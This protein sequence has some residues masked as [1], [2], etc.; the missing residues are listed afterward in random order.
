MSWAIFRASVVAL[1]GCIGL[2]AA[3][4]PALAAKIEHTSLGEGI[5]LITIEGTIASGDEE[6]FRRL[7][8]QYDNAIVALASDGGALL[9]ALEIGKMI[10]LKEF[11]T[12]VLDGYECTSACALIWIA[13]STRF[14]GPRGRVGFH[15]SYRDEGGRKVETG[16]G[17]ALV[18]RYLTLLNLP[19]KAVLFATA[20]PPDEV[21]WLSSA[22]MRDAG[23]DFEV[24]GEEAN[25]PPIVRTNISPPAASAATYRTYADV[26]GWT[27]TVDGSMCSMSARYH[28]GSVLSVFSDE[29]TRLA[30][31]VQNKKWQSIKEAGVYQLSVEMDSMGAWNLDAVEASDSDGPG[32]AWFGNVNPNAND[33][34]FVAEFAIGSTMKVF[35]GQSMIA[36]FDLTGTRAATIALIR[37]IRS[38]GG[39][40]PFRGDDPDRVLPTTRVR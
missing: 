22:N 40:D 4:Q 19:E 18:G 30:F 28:D 23:I 6:K 33:D 11:P 2:A 3:S 39:N 21:L 35:R 24:F 13:G 27:I 5:E 17:N 12:L 37:C 7:S 25:P 9:S 20:A 1:A 36:T 26:G 38:V 15:A 31:W 34:S 32:L 14:L 29:S 10:R 16:L 8:V